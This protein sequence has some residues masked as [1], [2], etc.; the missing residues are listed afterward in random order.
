M[1]RTLRTCCAHLITPQIEE[2]GITPIEDFFVRKFLVVAISLGYF[3]LQRRRAA[4]CSG[5][6]ARPECWFWRPRQ[7]GLRRRAS[8]EHTQ[9]SLVPRPGKVRAGGTP[10]PTLGT[11]VLPDIERP[12]YTRESRAIARPIARLRNSSG[13]SKN[14]RP[15]PRD[16]ENNSDVS[17]VFRSRRGQRHASR[18]QFTDSERTRCRFANRAG[19][20]ADCRSREL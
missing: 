18:A 9:T 14:R 20:T 16:H 17:L 4:N 19:A 2:K 15:S 12:L 8:S 6:R 11:S 5:E 1:L 10:A 7:N 3:T 13:S